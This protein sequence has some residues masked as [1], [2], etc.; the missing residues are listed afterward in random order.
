MIKLISVIGCVLFINAS[1]AQNGTQLQ[2]LKHFNFLSSD[3]MKSREAGS[4]GERKTN[5]YIRENWGDGKRTS[6]YSWEYDLNSD[7]VSL[8]SEMVGTFLYNKS[9]ATILIAADLENSADIAVLLGIQNELSQI[10]LDVN[11]MIVGVTSKDNGHDGLDYLLTHMPKKAR[12]IR[13]L[14]HLSDIGS[15]TKENPNLT[16]ISTAGIFEELQLIPNQF[17]LI[18]GETSLLANSDGKM[19]YEKGIQCLALSSANQ[20]LLL[21]SQWAHQ[22]QE[23]IV[24]WVITK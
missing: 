17:E 12:D 23:F 6:F 16:V 20:S 21:D 1:I 11:V 9:K 15:L 2:L 5:N 7:T 19:Y 8:K 10:K 13:L 24:Q 14:I 22:L 4:D 3:V 18:K